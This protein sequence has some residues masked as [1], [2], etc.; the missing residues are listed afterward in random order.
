MITFF[1][2]F[3]SSLLARLWCLPWCPTFCYRW[4]IK[5]FPRC[6]HSSDSSNDGSIRYPFSNLSPHVKSRLVWSLYLPSSNC[7]HVES[8]LMHKWALPIL[9]LGSQALCCVWILPSHNNNNNNIFT[10][11]EVTM[12][13]KMLKL[14]LWKLL[15]IWIEFKEFWPLMTT[16][17]C[18]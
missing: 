3:L 17:V 16:M 2:Y 6:I 4:P 14:F 18:H 9:G 12:T 5:A 8:G 11:V 15:S 10:I 13:I 1:R 7:S